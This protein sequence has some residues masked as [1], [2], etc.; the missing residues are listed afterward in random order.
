MFNIAHAQEMEETIIYLVHEPIVISSNSDFTLVN[1]VS[2]GNGSENNPWIIENLSIISSLYVNTEGGVGRYCVFMQDT[3]D[4]FIIRNCNISNYSALYGIYMFNVSNCIIENNVIEKN[5]YYG[6]GFLGS[7]NIHIKNNIVNQHIEGMCIISSADVKIINNSFSSNIIRDIASMFN[8]NVNITGNN[9][10]IGIKI[11]AFD[12]KNFATLSIDESNTVQDRPIYYFKNQTNKSI[13]NNAGQVILFNCSEFIIQNHRWNDSYG[14]TLA[15][16]N[17][18]TIRNNSFVF[19]QDGIRFVSSSYNIIF[20][21]L[22]ENNTNGI[23]IDSNSKENMMLHNH[24]INNTLQ[25]FD[26]GTNHWDNGS[27]GNYWSDYAGLDENNDGIG[28]TPYTIPGGVNED[29][30]PLYPLKEPNDDNNTIPVNPPGQQTDFWLMSIVL[31]AIIVTF[32]LAIIY[33]EKKRREKKS[34]DAAFMTPLNTRGEIE[35]TNS[36]D[37]EVTKG[38]HHDQ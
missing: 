38:E 29:K 12:Y 1:G 16:S 32:I 15:F 25:A 9:F 36:P 5:Y 8:E 27:E 22:F 26:I 34:G 35:G 31:A 6:I 14:I 23:S 10:S 13:P 28:D 2:G 30:Y 3:T 7:T 24:F 19:N 4:Y 18:N 21:N 11:D 17:N 37:S 20:N 33:N